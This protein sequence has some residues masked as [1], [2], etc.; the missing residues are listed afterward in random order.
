MNGRKTN[1][2]TAK[3]MYKI[4]I[5]SFDMFQCEVSEKCFLSNFQRNLF[6]IF[7]FAIFNF[8]NFFS[9]DKDFK[10]TH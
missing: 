9:Q 7:T 2:Q 5:F 1:K 10:F 4:A 3:I 8:Q 6:Q